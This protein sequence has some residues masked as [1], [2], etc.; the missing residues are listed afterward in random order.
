MAAFRLGSN[1][2]YV[3]QYD[4]LDD[5]GLVEAESLLYAT[6]SPSCRSS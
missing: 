3:I 2:Q 5:L 1:G 4:V 6:S